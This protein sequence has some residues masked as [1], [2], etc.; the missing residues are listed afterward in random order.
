MSRLFI[1]FFA[2][3]PLQDKA[4]DRQQKA[5]KIQAWWLGTLVHRTRL[6]TALGACVIQCWWRLTLGKKLAERRRVALESYAQQIRAAVRLQ[7][8]VRMWRV[9]LHYCRLLHAA[10]VIQAYWCWHSCHTCGFIQGSYDITSNQLGL[11]LEIFLGSQICQ[12]TDC[13]PF[14]VKK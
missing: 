11:E 9:R 13:I 1:L 8:Q 2:T 12:V 4:H 5:I 6:H 3:S 14:P 7:T 10:R